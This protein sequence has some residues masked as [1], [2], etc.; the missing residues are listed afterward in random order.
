MA[1][2]SRKLLHWAVTASLAGFLF[3]FDTVVISGAELEIQE[4]WG[5]TDMFH[6]IA[7]ASAIWGTVLGATIGGCVSDT[8]GRKNTLVC[9]GIAYTVSAVGCAFVPSAAWGVWPLMLFRALGG[10]GVGVATVAAPVFISEIAPPSM[11]G[12]LSGMFQFCLVLGILVAFISNTILAYILPKDAAW[13]WMLGVEGFPAFIYT[14]MAL[15]LPESPRWLILIND[16]VTAK[17]VMLQAN[18]DMD[19]EMVDKTIRDI[20]EVASNSTS[21]GRFF[22]WRLRR[23]IFLAFGLAC[24]NQLSGINA[25]LYYAKR[26]FTKVGFGAEAALVQGI[27]VGLCN[28]FATLVGV[29]LI[30]KSGRRT[31]LQIGSVG[32]IISLSLI[33]LGFYLEFFYLVMPMV[34]AFI[35]FFAIGQ[36]T[37]IWVFLAEIFPNAQRGQGQAFGSLTHWVMCA[38]I[39][40]FF[41]PLTEALSEYV[42]FGIF[43]VFMTIQ[44]IFVQTSMPETKG[45]SLEQVQI[46]LGVASRSFLG[47]RDSTEERVELS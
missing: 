30:D 9:V 31:L 3:G 8:F 40:Q 5:L 21:G 16:Q 27:G 32:H 28:L 22:T 10:V 45:L 20:A 46:D 19:D 36:G 44:L 12:R 25:I 41:P 7:M 23:P 35:F 6:G 38:L 39:T 33:S 26:I 11:R 24:L 29:Y 14:V 47:S 34:F 1:G 13:R 42:V 17:T 43:A 18:P 37:V 4:L 2:F 15:R